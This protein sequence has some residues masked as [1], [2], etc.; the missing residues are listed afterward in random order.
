[1]GRCEIWNHCADAAMEAAVCGCDGGAGSLF[2]PF[3]S[4]GICD[5]GVDAGDSEAD[6]GD[7]FV[8]G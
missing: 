2:E 3:S 6:A 4:L 1:M 7:T 5:A 8:P